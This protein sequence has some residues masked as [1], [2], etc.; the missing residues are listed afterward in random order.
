M[1][2]RGELVNLEEIHTDQV[3]NKDK[4]EFIHTYW[5]SFHSAPGSGLSRGA[6]L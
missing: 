3:E 1:S 6:P 4:L 2:R 5:I